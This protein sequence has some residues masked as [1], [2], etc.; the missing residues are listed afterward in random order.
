MHSSPSSRR[1]R[2]ALLAAALLVVLPGAASAQFA[3]QGPA[4]VADLAEALSGS[5]VNISTSQNVSGSGDQGVTP[6]QLPEGSPFQDFFD[7]YFKDR[8]Q[9]G[10]SR[11]VQ[12]LGSGFVLD[13]EKGIIVTKTTSSPMR[14]RS[15][16]TSPTARS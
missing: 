8:G 5:V 16:S 7:E 12:S 13:A 3:P 11:K 15:K 14:T 2:G 4:S 10:G 1:L 9:G 6:P